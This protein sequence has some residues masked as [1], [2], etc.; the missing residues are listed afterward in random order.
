MFEWPFTRQLDALKNL[1][2]LTVIMS[3]I[4]RQ[5]VWPGV[6][7]G[8]ARFFGS[9]V[10]EA[11]VPRSVTNHWLCCGNQW[12][13]GIRRLDLCDPRTNHRHIPEGQYIVL[14]DTILLLKTHAGGHLNWWVTSG[15]KDLCRL[16]C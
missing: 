1:S 13:G 2:I 15:F 6:E 14:N 7:R 16:C 8:A 3:K 10:D 11:S 12:G 5:P 4:L 9:A